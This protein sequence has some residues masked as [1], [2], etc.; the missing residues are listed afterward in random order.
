MRLDN[1]VAIV[2]GGAQGIGEGAARAFAQEGAKLV[3]VDINGER[4]H[5]V[6]A[7]IEAAGGRAIAVEA[8]LYAVANTD[9]MVEQAIAAFGA[10]HILLASAGIFQTAD[11]ESTTEELWDRHLDLDLRSVFFSIK[12]VTPVMKRQRYGK[13]IT[14]GSIAGLVGFLN[15]PAYCAAKGGIVNLTRAVACELAPHGITV[16]SIAPGPVET[17]INDPFNWRT[18]A[19]DAHRKYLADRTPSGVSFYK[20]E[21]MIG[22]LVYLA[23]AESNAVTGVSIPVDGGW[24]AW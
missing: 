2:T 13:I 9:R 6:A 3:V 7:S 1:Q 4:A 16:N 20:V 8:D 15:S 24:V 11:I 12:A 22:T 21:D 19:G 23:S 10:V 14:V 18:P 5:A 17:A